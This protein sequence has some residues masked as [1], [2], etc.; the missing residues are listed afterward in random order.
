MLYGIA[1]K[2]VVDVVVADDDTM[3][4]L[5]NKVNAR[6]SIGSYSHH[7]MPNGRGYD[8]IILFIVYNVNCVNNG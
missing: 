5:A 6:L 8:P 3:R 2:I 1:V 7:V 4:D